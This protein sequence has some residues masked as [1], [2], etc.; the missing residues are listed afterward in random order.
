MAVNSEEVQKRVKRELKRREQ[1]L[2]NIGTFYDHYDDLA[3]VMLTRR[4]GFRETTVDGDT[5]NDDIFDGTPMQG[6]RSLANTT[7]AMIRPEGEVFTTIKLENENELD[8][9]G[10][11]WLA[12]STQ[13]FDTAVRAPITRFRQST[14]EVDLDLVVFG[15][16]ILF[17][18]LSND[19]QNLLFKSVHLK[20]GV[21]FFNQEGHAVGMYRLQNQ[22][23]W[24]WIEKFKDRKLFHDDTIKLIN[25]DK[26][27]EKIKMIHAVVPRDQ[28]KFKS[29]LLARNFAWADMWI[30]LD[31]M[32]L[33]KEGGFNE[34]PFIVPRWNTASGEDMGRSPGM[35][36]LPDSNTLQAMGETILVAGQRSAD[37]PLM[38][39]NDGAF[40]ELNTFPGGISYYDVETAASLRGKNPF[41]PLISGAN[42]PISRDMQTDARTQVMNAF[43]KNILNLPVDGPQMTATEIIQRKDEFIREVG[44]VFG[45]FETDYNLPMAQRSFNIMMREGGFAPIPDSLQGKSIKF[46]FELPVTKIRKQIQAA[47]ARQWVLEQA[48]FAQLNPEQKHLI[49]FEAI[50][51]F[52]HSALG[53]PHEIINS[54]EAFEKKVNEERQAKQ[55]AAEALEMQ[56]QAELAATGAKAAKDIAGADLPIQN[57]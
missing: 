28:L 33:V 31:K 15:T 35:V 25:E 12:D 38:A 44:P 51:R 23:L 49:N 18:G 17:N 4:G 37:P 53:L 45:I 6:A 24:Q 20:D 48:E 3:N 30:E 29:P 13:R 26:L 8:E 56:E 5:R 36:A 2:T 42:L 47:A 40:N 19:R 1:M 7:G 43:F 50:G 46:Q 52:S 27:D 14:G 9:E 21:P 39:P 32:H 41:F 11:K 55:Q 34:F 10:N 57:I 22:P 16:G 54:K